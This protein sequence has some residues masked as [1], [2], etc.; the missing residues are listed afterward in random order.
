MGT[1]KLGSNEI[2]FTN[3]GVGCSLP[4]CSKAVF[5]R[6][7]L[8]EH[9]LQDMEI[10]TVKTINLREAEFGKTDSEKTEG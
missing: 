4:F 5:S 10:A 1:A 3:I 2:L 9:Y 6:G 8:K 7:N